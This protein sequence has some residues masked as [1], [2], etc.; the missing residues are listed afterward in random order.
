[1][2]LVWRVRVEVASGGEQAVHA[3]AMLEDPE[4]RTVTNLTS[5]LRGIAICDAAGSDE[6]LHIEVPGSLVC[7]LRAG[8][9][10]YASSPLLAA[11]GLE[12]G[13]YDVLA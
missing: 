1:V 7:T 12:G 11:L 3:Q 6:L 2:R 4:H 8:Q 13:R 9:T 10:L 5:D